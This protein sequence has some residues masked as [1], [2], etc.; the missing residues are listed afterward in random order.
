[1]GLV[2]AEAGGVAVLL[3]RQNGTV[4]ALVNRCT[5]R[6]GPLHEGELDSGCV[7]CPWHGSMFS[8]TDGSMQA[9]PATR[10]Q[11]VLETRI[12]NGRVQVRRQERRTMRTQPVGA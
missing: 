12:E 3:S 9:G 5:H 10:P 11:A 2:G 8:L 4:T 6:G 1:M 7:V